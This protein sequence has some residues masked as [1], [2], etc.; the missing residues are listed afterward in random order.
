V[1]SIPTTS[2]GI[3]TLLQHRLEKADLMPGFTEEYYAALEQNTWLGTEG[4]IDYA[5][6]TFNLDALVMPSRGQHK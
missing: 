6:R 1:L 3:L 4:S 2:G 5:L